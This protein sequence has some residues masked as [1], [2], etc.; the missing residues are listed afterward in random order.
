MSSRLQVLAGRFAVCRLPGGAGA[1]DW[2]VTGAFW[3]VFRAP[4]ELT[5]IC[6][7]QAVPAS[8]EAEAGWHALAVEGPLSFELTGVLSALLAPLVQGGIPV[9]A[10]SGFSTDYLLVKKLGPALE[11][12]RRAGHQVA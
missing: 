5:V 2:A 1:P 3:Q 6:P 4:G 12:L 10:V 11:A 8:V 9:L 7:E